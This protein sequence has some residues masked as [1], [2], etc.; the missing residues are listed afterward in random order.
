MSYNLSME[1]LKELYYKGYVKTEQLSTHW[2]RCVDEKEDSAELT[3][4]AYI[5]SD[6]T[7]EVKLYSYSGFLGSGIGK[8]VAEAEKGALSSAEQNL[9][10]KLTAVRKQIHERVKI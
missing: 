2:R 3:F 4:F 6:M 5:R 1:L 10:M 7:I 8:T 9:Y